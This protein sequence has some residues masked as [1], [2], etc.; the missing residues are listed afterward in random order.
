MAETDS[1]DALLT[2]ALQDLRDAADRLSAGLAAIGERI[3]DP[4][5]CHALGELTAQARHASAALVATGR[6]A[7]GPDNIW[8]Q[9][10]LDDAARDAETVLAGP[11]LDQALAGAVR[12]GVA[13]SVIAYETAIALARAQRQDDLAGELDQLRARDAAARDELGSIIAR[14]AGV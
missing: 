3:T 4:G 14:L 12:K 13:A 8:M 9:G 7:G 11:L 2:V 6:G 10:V 5:L 1:P